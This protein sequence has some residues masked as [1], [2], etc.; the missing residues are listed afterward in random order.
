MSMFRV[1]NRSVLTIFGP[2][3]LKLLNNIL[4]NEIKKNDPCYAFLLNPQGRYLYDF[5]IIPK[6]DYILIDCQRPFK[7]EI[8][9]K[10]KAY[11][12]NLKCKIEDTNYLVFASNKE[13]GDLM[14][15]GLG[16]GVNQLESEKSYTSVDAHIFKDPRSQNMGFRIISEKP[17]DD[18]NN[19]IL[20]LAKDY[21]L[22]RIS[23]CIPDGL[24]DMYKGVT[25]IFE[26]PVEYGVSWE[27]GC[28]IGQEVI[29]KIKYKG[30]IKKMMRVV[31]GGNLPK[32]H[33]DIF[34]KDKKE[35]IGRMLS[36]HKNIGLA[37]I[38]I[39]QQGSTIDS[40]CCLT[41]ED[42]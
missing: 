23:N 33:Q 20:S 34:A 42:F 30:K 22:T 41:K 27:K 37:L 38:K 10:L 2:D 31:R 40:D 25:Y 6:N 36:S 21:E 7:E 1:E 11:K 18:L 16:Q 3:S 15:L 39:D 14:N 4:T 12:I 29:A 28:Y 8:L 26:Y 19:N 17:L 13:I 35:V 24:L 9:E 5:F 32:C